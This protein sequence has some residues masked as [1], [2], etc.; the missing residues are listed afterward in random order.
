MSGQ[1]AAAAP[2]ELAA[3]EVTDPLEGVLYTGSEPSG[4]V[5]LL[6]LAGS[7]GRI[8]RTR[9]RIFAE[10][11]ITTLAI[12]WFGGPGQP[13]GPC[14]IPLETFTAAL[15]LLATQGVRRLGILGSS[16]GAEAAMVTAIRDPRVDAVIALSPTAYVWGWSLG[17][18][19]ASGE[20]DPC[21]SCWTWRGRPLDFVPM[22]EAWAAQRLRLEGPVA[23]RGWY[24]A[25]EHS[26]ADRLAAARIPVEDMRAELV[27]V[28]G[29][30]DQMW[31]SDGYAAQLAARRRT[32]GHSVHVIE[33]ADA[34][35]RARFPGEDPYPASP[36]F[37][38]GGTDEADAQL[39]A[40]A[41]PTILAV[42]RGSGVA[43]H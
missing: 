23:I 26:H 29:A 2:G 35:H 33:C 30:D 34:G 32:A 21:R 14:E 9:A 11:G 8:E 10:Q 41:W 38:Y 28:A 16:K 39:G 36:T 20:P 43:S 40:Q 7:S 17:G 12:R 42:L 19:D 25:S 31:P 37:A 24:D 3:R 13:A 18:S 6:V 15:D 27:L 5:G 22:D 4:G 1:A